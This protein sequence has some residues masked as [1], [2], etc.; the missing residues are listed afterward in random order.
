MLFS[1]GSRYIFSQSSWDVFVQKASLYFFCAVGILDILRH[2]SGKALRRLK[3][4]KCS[5]GERTEYNGSLFDLNGNFIRL[6]AHVTW[7]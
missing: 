1:I 2:S 4:K 7:E 6:N 5:T 3:S